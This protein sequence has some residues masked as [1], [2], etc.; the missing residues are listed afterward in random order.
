MLPNQGTG[1]QLG[2]VIICFNS[3]Y[4]NDFFFFLIIVLC[5]KNKNRGCIDFL[6]C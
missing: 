6:A 3:G 5:I 4:E 1:N 2:I